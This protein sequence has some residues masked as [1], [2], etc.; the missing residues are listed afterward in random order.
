MS[1]DVSDAVKNFIAALPPLLSIPKACE[2]RGCSRAHLYD[3]LAQGRARAVK[4]GK[5][6]RVVTESLLADMAALPV[7]EIRPTARL[8][9]RLAAKATAATVAPRRRGRSRKRGEA[10]APA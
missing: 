7:A 5:R 4:D 3:L 6:T 10:E 2:V 1:D 9:S 8:L